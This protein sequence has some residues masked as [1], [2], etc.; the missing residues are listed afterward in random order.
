MY[1]SI[2]IF[3]ALVCGLFVLC[4]VNPVRITLDTAK[5]IQSKPK[6]MK[7]IIEESRGTRRPQFI[8]QQFREAKAILELTERGTKYVD[9]CH[10]S[11][12][13]SVVGAI[14]GILFQNI[15]PWR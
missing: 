5:G 14:V 3:L 1:L 2:F 7:A 6:T 10:L 13:L 4:G 9:C 11:A 12:L 15:L 8:L